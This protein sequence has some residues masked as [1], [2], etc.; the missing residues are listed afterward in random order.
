MLG[1][2]GWM[3][4]WAG[5]AVEEG[6]AFLFWCPLPG[7][8]GITAVPGAGYKP[9]LSASWYR[10]ACLASA[11]FLPTTNLGSGRS[12]TGQRELSFSVIQE[13]QHTI[14]G[15]KVSLKGLQI[16]HGDGFQNLCFYASV[17]TLHISKNGY[18]GVIH[19]LQSADG[20]MA[21]KESDSCKMGT[22]GVFFSK[23][24]ASS[25]RNPY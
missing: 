1:A 15:V 20:I 14:Y 4:S 22:V 7:G 25:K 11:S 6:G 19:L 12:L 5:C 23:M 18:S 2:R 21:H 10:A 9:W 8:R 17:L 3:T 16:H 24:V 13:A